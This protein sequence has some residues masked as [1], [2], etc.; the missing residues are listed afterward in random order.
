MYRILAAFG[1]T[2]VILSLSC[3][4]VEDQ[5]SHI[6]KLATIAILEDSRSMGTGE[7][8][9]FLSDP[10]P[11]IRLRSV[12][13]LGRIGIESTVA[14]LAPL[15]TDS[16]ESVQLETAFALGQIGGTE[17]MLAITINLENE[18]SIDVRCSMIEALGKIGDPVAVATVL[19]Y[20]D[21]PNPR[22]RRSAAFAMSRIPEHNQ[23]DALVELS[24]DDSEEVRWMAVFAMFR[25]GDSAAFG[26]LRWCLKD[27]STLVRQFAARAIGA[28]G[29]SSGLDQLTERLRREE[30][31]L[32]KINLI[33]SI[34]DIGDRK[35]LK[36]L[37]NVLSD[38]NSIHVKAEAITA[39][40]KLKLTL[41]MSKLIPYLADENRT[42]RGA[43]M[44]TAAQIDPAF[45]M[46]SV[47]GFLGAADSYI[48]LRLIEGLSSIDTS[49]SIDLIAELFK[50]REGAVRREALSAMRN[51]KDVDL[52][53]YLA[54]GLDD[55]DFT[56]AITAI[57][58]I[59]ER[60][61]SN[62]VGA[63][64]RVFSQHSA[65]RNP[66]LRLT[67]VQEFGKW[68]DSL[69]PDPAM[70]EVFN[71]ALGDVDYR[72]REAAINAYM[73]IGIDHTSSLG[74]YPSKINRQTYNDIFSR[75]ASNPKA[76]IETNRGTIEIELLYDIAPKTV[77]NFADLAE[78][79]FFDN[80]I[81][82]RVIPGFV[83]QDGCPRG[84]G[85][86]GPGYSIRSEWNR[87]EYERGTV[88][89]AHS[90]KD[91]GGSQF[92]ISHTALPHLDGRYTVFG[93][94]TSG[95][96]V[97]DRVE[98]GDSIRAIQI[99]APHESN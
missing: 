22:I 89:M 42:I 76:V 16:V 33:R 63:V 99:V 47:E 87:K 55:R 65:D 56:V 94:V 49:A 38:D 97:V 46:Q 2:F 34:A 51:F 85:W 7:L 4:D 84:D 1:L 17:A 73:K 98:V 25:T 50:D 95:M 80:R 86:G 92:F 66:D 29:D 96:R 82:H 26:R 52:Q 59:V 32:V 91:T 14:D 36:S 28:L 78:S 67:V 11:E 8:L 75:Y 68:V 54:S 83:I 5:Y 69:S 13:A 43:A 15:M 93:Q 40:G 57:S 60:K 6:D 90:G 77:S 9:N 71:R 24:R 44:V 19:H 23:T 70:V 72:V 48:K 31:D 74:E 20:F 18:T 10:D 58:M 27:S 39:I 3:G 45:F 41:A 62:Y 53:P 88:G 35:A 79:G 81:W 30:S 37:L 21:D 12:Q 61:D 64:A